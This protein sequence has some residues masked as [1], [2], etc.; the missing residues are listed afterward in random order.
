MNGGGNKA[1]VAASTTASPIGA[2]PVE[3]A[4]I[5]PSQQMQSGTDPNRNKSSTAKSLQ[6][7]THP[8]LP[9]E[10]SQDPSLLPPHGHYGE[11]HDYHHEQHHQARFV[12]QDPASQNPL[13]LQVKVG[14]WDGFSYDDGDDSD[15]TVPKSMPEPM[16]VPDEYLV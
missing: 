12:S 3:P 10:V 1:A 13:D 9:R 7:E 5:E 2:R 4:I 8:S 11:E 6:D 15:A 16:P 14:A